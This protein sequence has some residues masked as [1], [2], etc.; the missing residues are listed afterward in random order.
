MAV[1]T[2]I[3]DISYTVDNAANQSCVLINVD[4]SHDDSFTQASGSH[5]YMGYQ[6]YINNT[7]KIQIVYVCD[8]SNRKQGHRFWTW[9]LNKWS[10]WTFL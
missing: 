8:E 7:L 1:A 10:D 3:I 2:G 4:N 6:I 9:W 5:L